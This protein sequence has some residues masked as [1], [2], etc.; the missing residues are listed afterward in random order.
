MIT[1]LMTSIENQRTIN[2]EEF[3]KIGTFKLDESKEECKPTLTC[4]R[5]AHPK[6]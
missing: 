4:T 5:L 6:N 3:L 2:I 1:F